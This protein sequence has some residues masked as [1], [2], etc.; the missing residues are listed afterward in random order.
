MTKLLF[1]GLTEVSKNAPPSYNGKFD[2]N[3][4]NEQMSILEIEPE[5]LKPRHFELIGMLGRG[6]YGEVYLARYKLD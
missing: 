4:I 3:K 5:N 1:K 2:Y 6:G